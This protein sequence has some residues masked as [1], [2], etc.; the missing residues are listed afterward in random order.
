[1]TFSILIRIPL[2]DLAVG[3]MARVLNGYSILQN[4]KAAPM[5]GLA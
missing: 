3:E 4:P 1:M 2:I 5:T